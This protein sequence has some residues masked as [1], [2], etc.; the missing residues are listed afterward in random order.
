MSRHIT[1][2]LPLLIVLLVLQWG[3]SAIIMS[4]LSPTFRCFGN[5]IQIGFRCVACPSDLISVYNRCI[6]LKD[7]GYGSNLNPPANVTQA[8]N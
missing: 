8:S 3:Q 7:P 4:T 2:P 6:A 1:I 5:S